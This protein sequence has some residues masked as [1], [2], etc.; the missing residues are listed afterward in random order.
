MNNS[1]IWPYV[2]LV[3]TAYP[4]YSIIYCM[5]L[6]N[7]HSDI[8]KH[9]NEA[10]LL[11]DGKPLS[12]AVFATAD[13]FLPWMSFMAIIWGSMAERSWGLFGFGAVLCFVSAYTASW[14]DLVEPIINK[15]EAR[16]RQATKTSQFSNRASFEA[17]PEE[18]D[19]FFSSKAQQQR[20]EPPQQERK[21]P[22]KQE[23]PYGF[24][25]RHPDDAALWAFVDDPNA[26]DG[27]RQAAFAKI[28]KREAER[29]QGKKPKPASKS[30][31]V[32][33]IGSDRK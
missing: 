9:L 20:R 16:K 28:L 19:A 3:G 18:D 7:K 25:K 6:N 17:P 10:S 23:T 8:V 12:S 2:Y 33:L 1:M 14:L 27:E 5:H 30:D 26:S 11:R 31:I 24:D 29:K 32:R 13:N 15:H 22:P 21:P 4:A